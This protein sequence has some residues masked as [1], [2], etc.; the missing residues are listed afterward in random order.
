MTEDQVVGAAK[1]GL[2]RLQDA[3]GG[4]L[5]D[6]NIQLQ[7][8]LNE[9]AGQVQSVVGQVKDRAQGAFGLAGDRAQDV[10]G[11]V[12]DFAREDPVR[13]LVI[14]VGVGLLLGMLLWGGRKVVH[15]RHS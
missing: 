12:A 15:L 11:E 7:G 14:G 3:A 4:L 10:Y 5:G 9:A 1:K 8:K 13:A 6:P 2:G